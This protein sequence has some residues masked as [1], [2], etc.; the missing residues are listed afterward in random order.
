[1]KKRMI[2][3]AS[4]LRRNK[5]FTKSL[6][7]VLSLVLIFYVIPSTIYIKAAEALDNIGNDAADATDVSV[8]IDNSIN[9]DSV[10]DG[11][12]FEATELREENVKHFRLSDGNYIAAQYNYP[13][14]YS[15]ENGEWQDIDNTLHDS[16]AEFSS[17]DARIKFAKK[18]TG[19]SS[20][21]TLHDGSSKITLSLIGA[22]KGTVGEVRNS[23]DAKTDTELQKMMH[24]EKLSASVIYRDILDGVDIEYVAHSKNIKEN[25]I[26]KKKQ[27]SYSYLFELKLNGLTPTL[28]ESGDIELSDDTTGEIKYTIPAPV[29]FDASGEYALTALSAYTLT[30]ESGNK[31]TLT[32]TVDSAW[33]NAEERVFPVTVDPAIVGVGSMLVDTYID[34]SNSTAKNNAAVTLQ[35][36][37]N[38]F[39]YIKSLSMP[40][41]SDSAY[42]SNATVTLKTASITP[43]FKT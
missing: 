36:S 13:V 9:T 35:A 12:L 34:G 23:E 22:E 26:V 14:H 11:I 37:Y 5:V 27:D 42:I 18:I 7:L 38:K 39:I 29:V 41:I 1:M 32:V 6:S 25:I 19:N 8:G 24:L 17:S 3:L 40:T 30:H 43:N 21:F 2:A 33:M 16:G 31:Y 28:T 4:F 15:D 20:L 10:L